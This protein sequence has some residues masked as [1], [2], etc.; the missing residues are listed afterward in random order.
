MRDDEVSGDARVTLMSSG[1]GADRRS[2]LLHPYPKR[3]QAAHPPRA[4][5]PVRLAPGQSPRDDHPEDVAATAAL[6]RMNEVLARVQELEEALDDPAQVWP[7]LRTAWKLAA[8]ESRPRMA[9]IVRQSRELPKLLRDLEMRIRR[10]L[11]RARERVP[12]D[13]V[14]EMDRASMRWLVRQPG[15]TVAERAGADQRILATVRKEEYDTL[16]NRVLRA[17]AMLAAMVAR[18]WMDEH[19]RAKAS[20]RYRF[21]ERHRR[22]CIRIDRDLEALGVQ[23]ATPGLTPNYVL[24][25]DRAYREVFRAWMKLVKRRQAEDDLWAW[26]AQTWTDFCILAI[27]LALDALEESELVAQSPMIWRGEAV[28]GRWF[29]QDRPLAVFWL[30][31]TGRIVELQAR[32]EAPGTPLFLSRAHVALRIQDPDSRDMDRKVA[33][34]TPHAMQRL[35]L[36]EAAAATS[37]R[38]DEIRTRST[39]EVLRDGLVLTPAH[40]DHAVEHAVGRSPEVVDRLVDALTNRPAWTGLFQ[41]WAHWKMV[42]QGVGRCAHGPAVESRI[43][44]AVF[45]RPGKDWAW[46]G[47][48]AC[49]SFLLSRSDTAPQH[50]D[51]PRIETAAKVVVRNFEGNRGTHYT[52]FFYAPFLMVGLLRWRLV[53]PRSLVEGQDEVANDFAQT[54][55]DILPDITARSRKASNLRKYVPILKQILDELQGTG[56]NPDLLLDIAGKDET[57]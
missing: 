34:W 50:L 54:V 26:Q 28:Q 8:D 41:H 20:D 23:I 37:R 9:E 36:P 21:V 17:Y 19:P 47:E 40:G 7:R 1:L 31:E 14:Q 4:G 35:D 18:E 44:E 3:S 55:R 10:V 30:R 25:E 11:R 2:L 38:L 22:L 33:V 51:R 46:W 49:L 16:E 6:R 15:R 43:L 27:A 42:L 45:S 5:F 32:P 24:M 13:R 56:S 53:H 52:R 29:G 57:E 48:N 39:N 12:L